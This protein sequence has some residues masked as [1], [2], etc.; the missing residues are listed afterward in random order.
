MKFKISW[1]KL[2]KFESTV[3]AEDIEQAEKQVEALAEEAGE[4]SMVSERV[5]IDTKD[6][7]RL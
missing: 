2:N 7:V 5:C 3:E 1:Y 6:L 4:T